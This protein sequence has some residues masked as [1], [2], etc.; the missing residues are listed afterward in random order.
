MRRGGGGG[1]LKDG[2]VGGGLLLR[3]PIRDRAAKTEDKD[4]R[5]RYSSGFELSLG[6]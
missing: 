4:M 1:R 3:C 6:V 5:S 2:G